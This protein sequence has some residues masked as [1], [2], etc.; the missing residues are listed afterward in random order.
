MGPISAIL[1]VQRYGKV[2][3][4]T[5]SWDKKCIL[6]QELRGTVSVEGYG[7]IA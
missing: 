3:R 4:K 5:N 2:L 7:I 6:P 1:R